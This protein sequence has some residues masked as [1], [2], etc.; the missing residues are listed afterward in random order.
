MPLD[1]VTGLDPY[2]EIVVHAFDRVGPAV[3]HVT[4]L[5]EDGRPSVSEALM[6]AA[7]ATT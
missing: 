6:R 7:L 4:C 5:R 3:V 2:S 1:A